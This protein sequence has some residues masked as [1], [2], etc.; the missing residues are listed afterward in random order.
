MAPGPNW[1]DHFANLSRLF[2]AATEAYIT[3]LKTSAASSTMSFTIWVRNPDV[4]TALGQKVNSV[5]GYKFNFGKITS[6]E[7]DQFKL[8]YSY[9]TTIQVTVSP[10]AKVVLP[11]DNA[12]LRPENDGSAELLPQRYNKVV[13]ESGK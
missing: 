2:P 8:G 9:Q 6:S 7:T 3:N 1:L 12:P 5:P 13:S 10:E 11:E 4:I